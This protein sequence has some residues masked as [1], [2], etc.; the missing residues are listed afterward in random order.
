ML[1]CQVFIHQFGAEMGAHCT[2]LYLCTVPAS[3]ASHDYLIIADHL[4]FLRWCGYNV[5]MPHIRK[6]QTWIKTK[7]LDLL[8]GQQKFGVSSGCRRMERRIDH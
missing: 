3:R 4:V 8:V 2:I 7:T 6:Y 5:T 1:M